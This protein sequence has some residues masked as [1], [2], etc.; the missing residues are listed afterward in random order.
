MISSIKILSF[1]RLSCRFSKNFFPVETSLKQT[2]WFVGCMPFFII[3]LALSCFEPRIRFVNNIES[4]FTTNYLAIW[5]AV[6]QS[7]NRRNNF[8]QSIK[9]QIRS[10]S[11]DH[12]YLK[13][14]PWLDLFRHN[15]TCIFV[16]LLLKISHDYR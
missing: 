3:S 5:M 10:K 7:F 15:Q 1:T 2:G 13:K 11:Q 8:H 6:F 9:C 4:A 16:T 12:C 14:Q